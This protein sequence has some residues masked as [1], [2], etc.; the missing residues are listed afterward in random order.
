MRSLAEVVEGAPMGVDVE[1]HVS[2][3]PP[4]PAGRPTVGNVLLTS[5]GDGTIP[6]VTAFDVNLD[7]IIEHCVL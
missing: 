5:K 1:D 2:A 6:A 4:I 7:F 3:V